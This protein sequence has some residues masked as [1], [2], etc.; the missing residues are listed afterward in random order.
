MKETVD[1]LIIKE[2]GQKVWM[3]KVYVTG[4][5]HDPINPRII[6]VELKCLADDFQEVE[7]VWEK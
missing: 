1:V 5:E 4:L 6:T 2:G 3:R 7:K